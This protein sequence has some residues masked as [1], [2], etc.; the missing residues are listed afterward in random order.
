MGYAHL[1]GFN[2]RGVTIA[3]DSFLRGHLASFYTAS[4]S[5]KGVLQE[6][7]GIV[8]GAGLQN[9]SADDVA[10]VDGPDDIGVVEDPRVL[11]GSK[12]CDVPRPDL[13]GFVRCIARRLGTY[14]PLSRGRALT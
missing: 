8:C 4:N 2:H 10:G 7:G 5:M 9:P 1:C 12:V 13:I 6:M 14:L 3:F 11:A